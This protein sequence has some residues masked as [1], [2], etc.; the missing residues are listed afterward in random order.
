MARTTSRP[1]PTAPRPLQ[2]LGRHGPLCDE[3]MWAAYQNSRT[4]T[5]LDDVVPLTLPIRRGLHQACPPC[6]RPYRPD[7]EGR[8][9]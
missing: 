4:L 1:P 2:P 8:R 3:T 9:A 6:H 7:E 5:T